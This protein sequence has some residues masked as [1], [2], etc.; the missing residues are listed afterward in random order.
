M[1]HPLISLAGLMAGLFLMTAFPVL[2]APVDFVVYGKSSVTMGSGAV[3]PVNAAIG[4]GGSITINQNGELGGENNE[5]ALAGGGA[6]TGG[7]GTTYVGDIIFSG[8]INLAQNTKVIGNVYSG[9]AVS[10]GNN[11]TV[12][13]NVVASGSISLGNGSEVGGDVH[14]GGSVAAG[15]NATIAGT[16]A[17][18][19][20]VALGNNASAGSIA[21]GAAAPTPPAPATAIIPNV[22]AFTAGGDN[23]T[24]SKNGSLALD[25]GSY[26]TLT[27]GQNGTVTLTSGTYYFDS[28]SFAQNSVLELD[29]SNG[30]IT[31]NIVGDLWAGSQFEI[32]LLGGDPFDVLF[33]VHGDVTIAQNAVWEGTLLATSGTVSFGQNADI[34]GA[35]F[36]DVVTIGQNSTFSYA[37]SPRLFLTDNSGSSGGSGGIMRISAPG[38][39]AGLLLGMLAL[40]A[41]RRARWA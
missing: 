20:S 38:S 29:L 15:N 14:A 21:N 32:A 8:S 4:S 7:S 36:G 26:G 11:V 16:A 25:V 41:V 27:V 28:L 2:A 30:G 12:T 40:A 22:T 9:G 24:V 5:L 37:P 23:H 17:A 10:M 33:E 34:S 31:I 39:L 18:G 1:K 35:I 13:G 6:Y 19:G 3:V